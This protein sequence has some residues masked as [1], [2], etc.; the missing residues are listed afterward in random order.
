WRESRPAPK[1]SWLVYSASAVACSYLHYF[2]LLFVFLHGLVTFALLIRAPASLLR[3]IALY[4][5]T[6]LAFAPWLPSMWFHFTNQNNGPQ[7]PPVES[8]ILLAFYHFV[9]SAFGHGQV[10]L[11]TTTAVTVIATGLM[12]AAAL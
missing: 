1:W 3:A 2:G 9:E 8:N 10:G 4:A 7:M 6:A 12:A 11:R 5:A